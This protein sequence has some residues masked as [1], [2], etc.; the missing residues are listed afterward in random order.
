[1]SQSSM[2]YFQSNTSMNTHSQKQYKQNSKLETKKPHKETRQVFFY[3]RIMCILLCNTSRSYLN[4]LI[5]IIIFFQ[6]MFMYYVQNS[7]A[8]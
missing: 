4:D 8:K 2:S 6:I 7:H 5:I 1:M 3:L